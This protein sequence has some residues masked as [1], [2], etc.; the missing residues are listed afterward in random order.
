MAA[1]MATKIDI[2]TANQDVIAIQVDP[3]RAGKNLAAG[4][5]GLQIDGRRRALQKRCIELFSAV[6]QASCADDQCNRK[7]R[8]SIAL[9]KKH[10]GTLYHL[11]YELTERREIQ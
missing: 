11:R 10:A 7:R 8:Q 1:G 6:G 9:E 5:Q 4:K 3:I 2:A